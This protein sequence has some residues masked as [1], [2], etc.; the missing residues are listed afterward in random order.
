MRI[1]DIIYVMIG[2]VPGALL[3]Y[4]I[5]SEALILGGLPVSVLI[6][7]VIGSFIL[8]FTMA[9]VTR[10]GFNAEFIPLIGVGFCGSL[11][12]MSTFA[13]EE[14]SLLDAAKLALFGLNIILNVGLSIGAIIAGQA[15]INL[16][17]SHVMR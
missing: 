15:V 10:L 5:T 14:V 16:I 3:R 17:L 1:E 11:T 4:A 8:G 12:T 2:A 13:Y 7:N 6:V 9:G